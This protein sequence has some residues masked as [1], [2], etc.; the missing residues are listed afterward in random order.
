MESLAARLAANLRS[1]SR[2]MALAKSSA[3]SGSGTWSGILTAR[4]RAVVIASSPKLDDYRIAPDECISTP[5]RG[6]T[7]VPGQLTAW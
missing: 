1:A 6:D 3:D 7:L 5:P 2:K 4:C